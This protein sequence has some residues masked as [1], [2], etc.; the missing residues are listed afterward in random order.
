ARILKMK[1][2]KATAFLATPTYVLNMSEIA[3]TKLGIDPKDLCIQKITVA[4]EPGGSIPNT[5]KRMEEAWGAKVYDH[6]GATEIGAWSYECTS[7]SGLHIN[8]AL[9][10]V[11]IEDTV[12]GEL[13][14]GPG[15]PGKMVITALDRIAQPCI[16]FD[17]ND[18]IQ[19]S[20][21]KCECG[22]TFRLIKGGVLGRVDDITKVKGVLFSPSSIEEVIR[23]LPECGNEYE[24]IVKKVGNVDDITV[25]VELCC[26]PPDLDLLKIKLN[27]ML[28]LKTNLRCNIDFCQNGSLPRYEGKA[29][30]F[31]DLRNKE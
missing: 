27:D 29:K 24:I 19:W 3:K 25:R 18:L 26:V 20:N 13:I 10:L 21:D 7:Q 15:R 23:S 22:R 1:Q 9:F 8:E 30:R 14:T 12:T 31:K 28:R 6:V 4:G 16:R 11:E 5:K 17:S 2:L